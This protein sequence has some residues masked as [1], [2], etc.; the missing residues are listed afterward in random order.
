MAML[1]VLGVTAIDLAASLRR[2]A[3]TRL[4]T[5]FTVGK[6]VTIRRSP[7]DVYDFLRRFENLPRYLE[8]IRTVFP[9]DAERRRWR[10][11]SALGEIAWEC[12][13][14]EDRPDRIAWRSLRGGRTDGP[15][16][17]RDSSP[18]TA[19]TWSCS[20]SADRRKRGPRASS[21]LSGSR[22]ISSGV[23][24]DDCR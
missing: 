4:A 10:A 12:E 17:F 18:L 8:R 19:S 1:G 16:I 9:L 23:T 14:V 11:E 7:E 21:R 2:R 13:I 15:C 6:S 20:T 3:S 22:S 24:R 5:H